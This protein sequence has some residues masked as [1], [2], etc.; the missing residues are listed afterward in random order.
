MDLFSAKTA[1][2]SES[3]NGFIAHLDSL[4]INPLIT[5]LFALAVV[6]FLYGVFEFIANQENEEKKT[7]GKQHMLW[8]I[9]GITIMLGV[10]AIMNML[11]STLG[12]TGINPEQGT[13]QLQ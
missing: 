3:L 8:G 1:Y 12:I 6:F 11:L 2:A 7:A 9:I 5:F 10:F 13:V 4:I